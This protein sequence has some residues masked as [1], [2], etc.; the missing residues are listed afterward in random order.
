MGGEVVVKACCTRNW[1]IWMA[2]WLGL[3]P[4]IT[5]SW[6]WIPLEAE[7]ELMTVWHF[8][9]QRLEL[10]HF[11]HLDMTLM[12]KGMENSQSSS[13]SYQVREGGMSVLVLLN[14]DIPCLCK[15]CKSRSV[16]FWRSQLIWICTVCHSVCEFIS[17]IWFNKSNWLTIRRGCGIL[18]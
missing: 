17:A 7:I 5:G 18:I 12:M 11:H 14:P 3:L 10:S 16:G 8:I 9:A 1:S 4:W 2:K 6:V 15:Q 13:C